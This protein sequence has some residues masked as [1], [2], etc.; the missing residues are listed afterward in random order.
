MKASV[1]V[2]SVNLKTYL[3]VLFLYQFLW[4]PFSPISPKMEVKASVYLFLS[5]IFSEFFVAWLSNKK[6]I[7]RSWY[8]RAWQI[9]E[10]NG[11]NDIN[12]INDGLINLCKLGLGL[13]R[14]N[15]GLMWINDKK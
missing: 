15:D 1:C 5:I 11:I 3:E 14:I 10:I 8:Y 9:N 7:S 6:V 12:R 13:M 4:I 2:C